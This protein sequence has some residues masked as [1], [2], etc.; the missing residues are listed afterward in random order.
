MPRL[1]DRRAEGRPGDLR[2]QPTPALTLGPG[3][4]IIVARE[5][6]SI[7]VPL[8]ERLLLV[9]VEDRQIVLTSA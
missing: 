3:R 5:D 6:R 9:P 4:G 8:E 7:L 1:F 2:F